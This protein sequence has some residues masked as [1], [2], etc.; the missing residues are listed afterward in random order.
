MSQVCKLAASA[1]GTGPQRSTWGQAGRRHEPLQGSSGELSGQGAAVGGPQCCLCPVPSAGADPG[2]RQGRRC[3][4][5]RQGRFLDIPH[6]RPESSPMLPGL[7]GQRQGGR[8]HTG[9]VADP[10][11]QLRHLL[12]DGALSSPAG[13]VVWTGGDGV[14]ACV[15]L[16]LLAGHRAR[17]W[18]WGLAKARQDVV[19]RVILGHKRHSI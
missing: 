11:F 17:P 4:R 15:F 14:S 1:Q 3:L 8:L 7:R 12:L 2:P 10:I 19:F 5:G 18:L 6:R 16:W 9:A 13:T